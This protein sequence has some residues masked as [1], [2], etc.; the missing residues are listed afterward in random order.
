MSSTMSSADVVNGSM[1]EGFE[2]YRAVSRGAVASLILALF[3]PLAFAFTSFLIVPVVGAILGFTAY[4]SVK[5]YPLELTGGT[6]AVIGTFLCSA[7]FISAAAYHT[8]DY[9]TEVPEGYTRITFANLQPVAEHPELPV[10]PQSLQLN[11]QK[12]FV[13]GYVHPDLPS[14]TNIKRFILVPDMGTCCF[15]GQPKLTDMIEVNL[16]D[17]NRISYTRRKRKLA[18]VLRVDTAL[19]PIA[20]LTGVFYQ[21]DAD[22]VE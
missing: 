18:G 20:G 22:Q 16:S 9:S 3:S 1:E 8:Y 21:L 12:I 13:K 6:V 2:P 4:R 5:R 15:G 10:S 19:K 17:P 14:R 11:G 7:L